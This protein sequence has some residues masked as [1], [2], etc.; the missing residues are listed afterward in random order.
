[1]HLESPSGSRAER[2]CGK[3]DQAR[4]LGGLAVIQ[5]ALPAS[6]WGQLA[7]PRLAEGFDGEASVAGPG[8]ATE[9]RVKAPRDREAQKGSECFLSSGPKAARPAVVPVLPHALG[10]A[11]WLCPPDL[12][13]PKRESLFRYRKRERPRCVGKGKVCHWVMSLGY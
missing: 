8:G 5:A 12:P 13:R 4:G 9:S 1:M 11:R 10:P 6:L 7:A 2:G 3:N